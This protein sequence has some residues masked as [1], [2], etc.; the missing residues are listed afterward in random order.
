MNLTHEGIPRERI[1]NGMAVFRSGSMLFIIECRN[2]IVLGVPDIYSE[3]TDTADDVVA[4]ML[5]RQCGGLKSRDVTV[6]GTTNRSSNH[7][8]NELERTL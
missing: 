7:Q 5:Y 4:M 2:I 8:E 1:R 3:A 6:L